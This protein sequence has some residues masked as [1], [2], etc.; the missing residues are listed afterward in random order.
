MPIFIPGIQ[1]KHDTKLKKVFVSYRKE[2]QKFIE[3]KV[4]IQI[5]KTRVIIGF[6]K[7]KRKL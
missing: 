2:V 6:V 4:L 1:P 3:T 5:L 7:I